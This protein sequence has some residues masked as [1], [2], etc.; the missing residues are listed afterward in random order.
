L[1]LSSVQFLVLLTL[2]VLEVQILSQYGQ[3]LERYRFVLLF[4]YRILQNKLF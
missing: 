4:L 1:N 2:M 3:F